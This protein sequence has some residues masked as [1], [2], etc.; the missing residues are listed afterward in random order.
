MRR[1][2][3]KAKLDSVQGVLVAAETDFDAVGDGGMPVG[4]GVRGV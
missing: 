2:A 3:W 1:G 4:V